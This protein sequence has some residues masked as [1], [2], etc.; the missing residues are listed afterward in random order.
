MIIVTKF[1]NK[2]ARYYSGLLFLLFSVGAIL[3]VLWMIIILPSWS[4][5]ESQNPNWKSLSSVHTLVT[6]FALISLALK[7]LILFT[8]FKFGAL[9]NFS[10][11]NDDGKETFNQS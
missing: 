1:F 9:T 3:D 4:S 10:Y 5:D 8:Q 11:I 7:G 2:E 6:V